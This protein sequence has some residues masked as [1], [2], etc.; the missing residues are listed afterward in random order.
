MLDFTSEIR[1]LIIFFHWDM[2][3][4]SLT[5][6][7]LKGVKILYFAANLDSGN[8]TSEHFFRAGIKLSGEKHISFSLAKEY[9]LS[10]AN[11]FT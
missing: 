1:P 5:I 7:T 11:V 3:F 8:P 9:N 10:S 4:S 6:F 2:L